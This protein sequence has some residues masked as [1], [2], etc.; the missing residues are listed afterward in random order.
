MPQNG[1]RVDAAIPE[2]EPMPLAQTLRDNGPMSPFGD[3]I[4][5][6]SHIAA[7]QEPIARSDGTLRRTCARGFRFIERMELDAPLGCS[8]IRGFHCPRPKLD[9]IL[10]YVL[11]AAVSAA[12]NELVIGGMRRPSYLMQHQCLPAIRAFGDLRH[13]KFLRTNSCSC[14]GTYQRIRTF[15]DLDQLPPGRRH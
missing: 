1:S 15:H 6:G 13:S 5:R 2:L 7:T 11:G 4:K 8:I 14:T 9:P 12:E 10:S 3:L